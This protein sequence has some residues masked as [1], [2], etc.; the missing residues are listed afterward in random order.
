MGLVLFGDVLEAGPGGRPQRGMD[1]VPPLGKGIHLH[2]RWSASSKTGEWDEVLTS[3]LGRQLQLG[4]ALMR[5]FLSPSAG[6]SWATAQPLFR[7]SH[8]FVRKP[9][10][11]DEVRCRGRW[12]SWARERFRLRAEAEPL[13]ASPL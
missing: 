5:V 1:L 4:P 12:R 11:L 10:T 13:V 7:A 6:A 8:D 9:S 3:D 2:A